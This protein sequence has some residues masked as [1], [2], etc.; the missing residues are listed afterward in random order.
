MYYSTAYHW[1]QGINAVESNVYYL[2]MFLTLSFIKHL[3]DLKCSV[4][5]SSPELE[6][7]MADIFFKCVFLFFLFP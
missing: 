4:S 2:Q 6:R 1:Y 3:A 7:L 5:F